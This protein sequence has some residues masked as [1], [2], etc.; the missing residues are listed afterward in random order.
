[1]MS[2]HIEHQCPQCWSLLCPSTRCLKTS[3]VVAPDY[4]ALAE[5][6]RKAD[7]DA[8]DREKSINEQ[9]EQRALAAWNGAR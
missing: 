4:Q 8:A 7:A 6:K 9:R 3:R 1:V 2:D 5:A